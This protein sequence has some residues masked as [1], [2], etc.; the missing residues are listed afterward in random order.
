M[1]STGRTGPGLPD[2]LA[3]SSTVDG[4]RLLRPRDGVALLLLDRPAHYNALDETV[5][6]GL[7]ALI[8][9]L[10]DDPTVRAVVLSGAGA[11]FCA[12]GDLDLIR[13]ASEETPAW[14][15]AFLARALR[16]VIA[17]HRLP[18]P[19][20]AA[21]NGPVAGAGFGLA[22]A[23]DVRI[24]TAAATFSA[25][26]IHMGLVPDMGLTW[27]LPRLVGLGT[28]VELLL[29]G[30][31]VEAGEALARGL[32]T[33]LV[34]DPLGSALALGATFAS[35]PPGAVRTTKAMLRAALGSDLESAVA[36]EAHEQAVAVH[37]PEFERGYGSWRRIVTGDELER[38]IR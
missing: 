20:V 37:G 3:D 34:D 6:L 4:V 33:R 12:G 1:T 17:L 36:A 9:G 18:Q 16:P 26:F 23:C 21:V 31:Q 5:L 29:S 35:M 14:G 22:L 8:D 7:E 28:A 30:R 2:S 38:E 15:E 32:V 27:L 25:P 19:T 24:A 11:A 10:A 13:K